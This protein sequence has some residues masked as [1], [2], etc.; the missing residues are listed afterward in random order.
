[1]LFPHSCRPGS[2]PTST[3]CIVKLLEDLPDDDHFAHVRTVRYAQDLVDPHLFTTTGK[4]YTVL[5]DGTKGTVHV[6]LIADV[7]VEITE[8]DYYI[9]LALLHAS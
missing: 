9:C 5:K 8:N 7:I 2:L 6:T 1:M 3:F 4:E